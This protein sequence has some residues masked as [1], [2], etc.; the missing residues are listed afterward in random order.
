M[1]GTL[2][3]ASWD[4]G[5]VAAGGDER[6]VELAQILA[7]QAAGVAGG[8]VDDDGLGFHLFCPFWSHMPMPP[9]TGSP[10]PVAHRNASEA[11]KTTASAMSAT[12]P[13]RPCKAYSRAEALTHF[14]EA[15][16][17]ATKP[18]IYL[19]AGV[20]NAQFTESLKMAAE[21]G[22]DYSG[23]LCGQG[24]WKEGIP[25]YA[26]HGVKAL[27][28]WLQKDGVANINAVNEAIRRPRRGGPRWG[29][30]FRRKL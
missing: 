15:A 20:S 25:V 5:L 7:D 12:S 21:A 4:A 11:R 16:A 26:Q 19:S 13:R 17:I 18:F 28:D 6:Q 24:D 30:R 1:P 8:A 14:R 2:S 22:T 27:E 29:W 3:K 9:S 10:A 23:V